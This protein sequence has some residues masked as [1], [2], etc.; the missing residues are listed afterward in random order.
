MPAVHYCECPSLNGPHRHV[1]QGDAGEPI[2]WVET[3]P[4]G[5]VVQ[6]GPV[7]QAHAVAWVGEFLAEASRNEGEQ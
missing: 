4:T 5:K 2:G 6:S 3:D 7:S 1:D